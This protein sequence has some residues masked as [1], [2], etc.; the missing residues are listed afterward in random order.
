MNA[1]V[2]PNRRPHSFAMSSRLVIGH[3]DCSS[4]LS[5][6]MLSGSGRASGGVSPIQQSEI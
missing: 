3:A 2:R 6:V 1:L 4:V 5:L